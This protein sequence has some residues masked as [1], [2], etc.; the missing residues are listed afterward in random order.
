MLIIFQRLGIT[1]NCCQKRENAKLELHNFTIDSTPNTRRVSFLK[2]LCHLVMDAILFPKLSVPFSSSRSNAA[3]L[4]VKGV[5]TS[6]SKVFSH[7]RDD[8]SQTVVAADTIEDANYLESLVNRKHSRSYRELNP[9]GSNPLTL[10]GT[11]RKKSATASQ[12][13]AK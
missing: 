11:V 4:F 12:Q 6:H 5:M 1:V 7:V 8:S 3:N 10:I 9:C 13:Y 2:R